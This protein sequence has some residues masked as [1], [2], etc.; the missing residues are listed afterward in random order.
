MFP[1]AN[2]LEAPAYYFYT[3]DRLVE[4]YKI[5]QVYNLTISRKGFPIYG[6]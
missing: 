1:D 2:F 5:T 3:Q 4:F 6:C